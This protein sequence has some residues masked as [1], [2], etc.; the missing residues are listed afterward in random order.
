MLIFFLDSF[1]ISIIQSH[2]KLT[3]IALLNFP[4][5]LINLNGPIQK[6][7]CSSE[8]QLMLS[9]VHQHDLYNSLGAD[10]QEDGCVFKVL[11]NLD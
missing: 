2:E 9:I 7:Y 1:I 3:V 11:Y 5:Y 4:I 8:Y 6:T 10:A